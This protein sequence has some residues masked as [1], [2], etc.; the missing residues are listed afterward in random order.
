MCVSEKTLLNA[1]WD[2]P[3]YSRKIVKGGSN[4]SMTI[5]YTYYEK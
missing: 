3:G 5:N 2:Q 1:F 4:N